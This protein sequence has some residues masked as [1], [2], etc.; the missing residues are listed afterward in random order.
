MK[1]FIISIVLLTINANLVLAQESEPTQTP[2][3]LGGVKVAM[4]LTKISGSSYENAYRI[5]YAAGG[6]ITLNSGHLFGVQGEL[7]FSQTSAST[8]SDFS[9]LYKSVGTIDVSRV[10][11]NYLG[12]PVLLNVGGEQLKFQLGPQYSILMNSNESFWTNG[13]RAFTSGDFAI[14]LGV[15]VNLPLRL[16]V[17][18]RDVIGL[19]NI[20]DIDN[21]D[22]WKTQQLQIAVGFKL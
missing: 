15:W 22:T 21:R 9:D 19:D 5:N 3:V 10:H 14:V 11:L 13:Q 1:K 2:F 20:N 4:N 18:F 16:N 7:L 6:Y 12:I 8:V 17:S